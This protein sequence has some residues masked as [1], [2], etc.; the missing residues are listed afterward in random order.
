MICSN[1]LLIIVQNFKKFNKFARGGGAERGYEISSKKLKILMIR[2][3][4]GVFQHCQV[5]SVSAS[6]RLFFSFVQVPRGALPA[7]AVKT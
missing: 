7:R 6:A 3:G 4:P 2:G 1:R 5:A